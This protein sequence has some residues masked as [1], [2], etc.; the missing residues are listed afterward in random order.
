MKKIFTLIL[1]AA[2]CGQLFAGGIVT[3]TNQSAQFVRMLSRNASTQID[4][5]Y[6][7][8]AGVVRMDDGFHFSLHNQTIFQTKTITSDFALLKN[9]EFVGD[10]KAPL[11]PSF[12][13]V[14]KKD[15]FALSFGFGPNGGGGSA[16][17]AN[18]L[19]SFEM[20]VASQDLP[21]QMTAAGIPTSDWDADIFFDGSSV[22][23]GSQLNASYQ[24]NEMLS[25]GAGVRMINAKNTYS[26]SIK[27]MVNPQSLL[28]PNGAGNMVSTP[29]FFNNMASTFTDAA[30]N[31][32]ALS[33][34][35]A[36][37]E[38][39]RDDGALSA[40]AYGMLVQLAGGTSYTPGTPLNLLEGGF[41]NTAATAAAY[42]QATADIEVETTQTGMA[43]TPIFS[44]QFSP[45]DKLDIAIKYELNTS[46][47][48]TNDTKK[49]YADMFKHDSSF[50]ADMPAILAIGVGYKISDK[51]RT[52]LSFNTYF[53]KQANWEGRED[54]VDKNLWEA[55]LGL[56]YD[57]NDMFTASIGFMRGVTGVGDE[58]QTDLS[59]SNSSTT[60]GLGV[61]I[62]PMENLSIDLGGLYVMYDDHSVDYLSGTPYAY[63]MNYAKTTTTLGIGV[64][65]KF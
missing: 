18:G 39:A 48:L 50:R 44:A 17:F 31:V 27:T 62:K 33:A 12:F 23:W 16:E 13:A 43:F 10:V 47:T 4:A 61:Q 15:K 3:N 49:D 54:K 59:Y 52:Q 51:F 8:P 24:I 21:G 9:K 40:E 56:E 6:F 64:N 2:T 60:I 7:N 35:Y 55:A 30:Q 20:L 36:N 41:T 5:V 58:Y 29:L 26:G 32:Q 63:N 25:V 53:D 19:P 14:Y 34:G 45:N 65:Y 11:F 37:L 46:L 22:Y 1:A 38:E 57:I 28:N 42:E